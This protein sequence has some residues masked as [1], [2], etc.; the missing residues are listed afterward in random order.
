MNRVYVEA[1]STVESALERLIRLHHKLRDRRQLHQIAADL[2][3][4]YPTNAG[5]TTHLETKKIMRSEL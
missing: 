3:V 2:L 4:T 1:G 5:S